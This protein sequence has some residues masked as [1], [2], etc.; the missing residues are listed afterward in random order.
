MPFQDEEDEATTPI[1]R[2]PSSL[3]RWTRKILLD[4]WSVK[5]LAAGI[6]VALWF[7]VTGQNTPVMQRVSGVQL[8]FIKD[9]NLEISNDIPAT[10]EVILAGSPARLDEIGARGLVATVDVG[11]QKP[12][13]RVVRLSQETVQ[14]PLPV[15]VTIQSF[16]PATIALR[17]EPVVQA[18]VDVEVKFEGKLGE[19]YE[20]A[21]FSTKPGRVR[22]RG[23]ADRVRNVQKAATETVS[24]DGR[25]ESFTLSNVA[26]SISDPKIEILDPTV[27]IQ[28]EIVERKRGDVHLGLDSDSSIFVA[29]FTF[30]AHRR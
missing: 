14:M 26:I 29:A 15:G 23:P 22:L 13:E 19:G 25:K 7:A 4:D 18:Q 27:D 21:G 2:P 10:V 11:N 17:L 20:L 24:L 28:V 3:E 16:R 1:P 5:L 12:G 6:T 9:E 8:N 30:S